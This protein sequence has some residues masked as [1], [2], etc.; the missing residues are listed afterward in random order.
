MIEGRA[1]VAGTIAIES[2]VWLSGKL[3]KLPCI[4]MLLSI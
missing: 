3:V 1:L 4:F 2:H